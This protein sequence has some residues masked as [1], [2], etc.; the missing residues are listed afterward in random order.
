[1]KQNAKD[2]ILL[3]KAQ[4]AKLM[5]FTYDV[6][7]EGEVKEEGDQENKS[8]GPGKIEEENSPEQEEEEEYE[9]SDG[10]EGG[11]MI[12]NDDESDTE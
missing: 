10:E 8:E 2:A 12:R 3:K 11:G 6:D 1:M 9:G 5:K 7:P 4:L